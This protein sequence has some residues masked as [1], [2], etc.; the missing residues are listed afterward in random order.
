MPYPK[1]IKCRNRLS[2][3]KSINIGAY[4]PEKNTKRTKTMNNNKSENQN[5]VIVF[6]LPDSSP[7]LYSGRVYENHGEICCSFNNLDPTVFK[8]KDAA[9]QKAKW[10]LE[11]CTNIKGVTY[12]I[13]PTRKSNRKNILKP[14]YR[15][16]GGSSSDPLRTA[17]IRSEMM[18]QNINIDV[19]KIKYSGDRLQKVKISSADDN[20]HIFYD[21]TIKEY[22]TE[23]DQVFIKF[24]DDTTLRFVQK[25]DSQ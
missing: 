19:V 12:E 4:S 24:D 10:L 17:F 9:E 18:G 1:N 20:S 15:L 14:I 21:N 6:N 5:F 7:R 22:K 25:A 23:N 2:D 3:T 16:I 11:H 8:D 13:R